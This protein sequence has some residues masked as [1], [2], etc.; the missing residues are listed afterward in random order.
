MMGQVVQGFRHKDQRR[1]E[2]ATGRLNAPQ[3]GSTC[4]HSI[5]RRQKG[6]QIGSKRMLHQRGAGA[7]VQV[8][9]HDV[10]MKRAT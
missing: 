6:A 10:T 3:C 9:A 1:V 2:G 7:L 8:G 5:F 4:V